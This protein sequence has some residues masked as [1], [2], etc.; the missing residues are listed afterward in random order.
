MASL[1][2]VLGGLALFLLGVRMLSSGMERLAGRRLQEWLDR[3]T[4][5]PIRGAV[6]GT[7][8]TA[9]IQSSSLLM[10]TMIGLINANL[11]ALEQAIG[12]MMGQGIG[13]TL[14]AQIAAF[15]TGNFSYLVIALGLVLAELVAN[16]T[17]QKYGQVILGFG[18]LFLGMETMSGALQVV[19]QGPPV[20]EWLAYLGQNYLTGV[21][22]GTIATAIVQSSSAVS[23]LVVAMGISGVIALPA[24]I[25]LVLGANI[26]TCVTG[27]IASLRLSH[28]SRRASLAQILINAFGVA[29]FLPFVSP[30]AALVARTSSSLARQIANAHT[31]FNVTVSALLLPF[32]GV[33]ARVSEWLVP[34]TAEEQLPRLAQYVDET[35]LR[36]PSIALAQAAR[37][38]GRLAEI[39]VEMLALIRLAVVGND[40]DAAQRVQQLNTELI[41]PL[42]GTVE[43][44]LNELL[45]R[46]ISEEQR[47]RSLR[48]KSM[49]TDVLRV[50]GLV[51][52]MAGAALGEAAPSDT[53]DVHEVE[54][55]DRLLRRTHR[56][57]A[58]AIEAVRGGDADLARLALDEGDEMGRRYWKTRKKLAKRL[59]SG[60]IDAHA[61][62]LFTALLRYLE[63][64]SD[65]A[66]HLSVQVMRS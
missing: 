3:M 19:M 22:V 57:Y 53:L 32:V 65:Q 26:G 47:T 35:L 13:T 2:Q 5:R 9:L 28:A 10:V 66:G 54:E 6:F 60:K 27:L 58:L 49:T 34:K 11:L 51:K 61:A 24:A 12:V 48:L 4:S 33:V 16:R 21:L 29:V 52:D 23:G 17:W 64:I 59:E 36:F 39:T 15:E 1:L 41:G 56:T 55:L 18:L 20:Q 45:Q 38:L 25:S 43:A 44:F 7:V 31:I 42:S 40:T 50:G 30:F 37:E 63:R 14:T 62:A 46:D 8:A